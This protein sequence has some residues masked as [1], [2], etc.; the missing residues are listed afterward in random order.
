MTYYELRLDEMMKKFPKIYFLFTQDFYKQVSHEDD[1]QYRFFFKINE[2]SVG[3]IIINKNTNNHHFE[4]PIQHHKEC[5]IV[6]VYHKTKVI[7]YQI[8]TLDGLPISSDADSFIVPIRFPAPKRGL[9]QEKKTAFIK[10]NCIVLDEEE[11]TREYQSGVFTVNRIRTGKASLG[12]STIEGD[13]QYGNIFG[14]ISHVLELELHTPHGT[15]YKT[16]NVQK[17]LISDRTYFEY[18]TELKKQE[19]AELRIVVFDKPYFV[20]MLLGDKDVGSS[21]YL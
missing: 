8:F 6:S 2:T 4:F 9:K 20:L 21:R 15:T 11:P 14:L 5:L 17:E 13:T 16:I 19:N 10:F 3:V 1:T 7:D 18:L 12:D